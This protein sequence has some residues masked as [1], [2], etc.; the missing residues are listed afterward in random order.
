[1]LDLTVLQLSEEREERE[2]ERELVCEAVTESPGLGGEA[3]VEP[4]NLE[5]DRM[6]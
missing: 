5:M 2:R 1:M 4:V 6:G 3:E